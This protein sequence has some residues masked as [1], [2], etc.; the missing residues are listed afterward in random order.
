L[1]GSGKTLACILTKLKNTIQYPVN[2]VMERM[3]AR[4]VHV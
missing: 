2:A 1:E 4:N 3:P